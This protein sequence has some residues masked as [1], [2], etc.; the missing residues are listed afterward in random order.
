MFQRFGIG[1]AVVSCLVWAPT[2]AH[3]KSIGGS[4]TDTTGGVLPGVTIEVR[5]PRVDRTGPHGRQ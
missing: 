5:S 2:L 3:A 1:I 4:V